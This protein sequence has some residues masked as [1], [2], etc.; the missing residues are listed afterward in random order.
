MEIL[1]L[2]PRILNHLT[3]AEERVYVRLWAKTYAVGQATCRATFE[4]LARTARLSWS[5]TKTALVK[6]EGR[7]LI[8]I[9]RFHKAPCVFTVHCI[10][11]A[12]SDEPVVLGTSKTLELL[13]EADGEMLRD[14]KRS[15]SPAK[16]LHYKE[17]ARQEETELDEEILFATFGPE[18]LKAYRAFFPHRV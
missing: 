8:E 6:L 7:G 3:P 14:V 1:E 12:P 11:L 9:A 16:I 15:L 4:D 10:A 13:T 5:T 2:I 17:I 18:R